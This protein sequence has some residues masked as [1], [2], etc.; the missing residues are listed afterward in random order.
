MPYIQN[1]P[2]ALLPRSDSK[3]PN[4][5]CR[6]LTSTGRPCRRAL[7]SPKPSHGKVP[8]TDSPEEEG[9][10][11][12]CWQHKDQSP[13]CTPQVPTPNEIQPGRIQG[14]TSIDTL[15]DRLGI[16]ELEQKNDNKRPQRKPIPSNTAR[17]NHAAMQQKAPSLL[18]IC[19]CFG[20]ADDPIAPR[21]VGSP[22]TQPAR[23]SMQ[24]IPSH[25]RR[26]SIPV[27]PSTNHAHK[28]SNS[29]SHQ[30][31]SQATNPLSLVPSNISPETKSVL[32]SE[33]SKPIS[34]Q[35]EPG[36]IYIFWLTPEDKPTPP[37][38]TASTL[39]SPGK[40]RPG[41]GQRRTSEV[42]QSYSGPNQKKTS[43]KT[44]LL[45]IGRANNVQRRLNE[46][47]RQC[48]YDVSLIRYYPYVES[49]S[50]SDVPGAAASMPRKVPNVHKV[51]RLIH[52]EL[53]EQRLRGEGKCPR[54]G[55]QHQEW[56]EV[57]AT[58]DGLKKVDGVVKRWVE[59]AE[60]N[61]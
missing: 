48:G 56:F 7:A 31:P 54:C 59:W 14:R 20:S 18:S 47:K 22:T 33:I 42:L 28:P 50:P 55:T 40:V 51:E 13:A 53:G 57:E 38:R 12:Y 26:S 16:L 8:T 24:Q 4:E 34:A 27:R 52:L 6:G 9:D 45:K 60:K 49:S 61:A 25:H 15:V 3:N 58:R 44:L 35:D 39:L 36:Y 21:P 2:E 19:C 11:A 17:P 32:L 46:W 30:C 5:T 29:S 43:S 10:P 37:T 1:T 23:P 41:S